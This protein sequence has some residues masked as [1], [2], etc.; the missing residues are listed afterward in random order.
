MKASGHLPLDGTHMSI[1]K[2]G[3]NIIFIREG[4]I[5]PYIEGLPQPHVNYIEEDINVYSLFT[6]EVLPP[7]PKDHK[8]DQVWNLRFD[9]ASFNEWNN[10]WIVLYSPHGKMHQYVVRIE[11]DCTNNVPKFEALLVGIKQTLRLGFKY[12]TTFG[13]LELIVNIIRKY[14]S[15]SNTFIK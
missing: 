4:R 14:Y 1:S 15:P 11:F 13:D 3:K 5:S 6:E 7:S 10:V 2:D 12:L 8:D 9:G